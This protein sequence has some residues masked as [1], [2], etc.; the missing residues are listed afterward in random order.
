M[1][2]LLLEASDNHDNQPATEATKAGGGWQEGVDEAMLHYW[3]YLGTYIG[4]YL[5]A[6]KVLPLLVTQ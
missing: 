4:T 5:P 1:D 2:P 3:V 6:S